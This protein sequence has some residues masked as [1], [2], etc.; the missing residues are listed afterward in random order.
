MPI[1]TKQIRCS[2]VGPYVLDTKEEDPPNFLCS[3]VAC[4]L[5]ALS[6]RELPKLLTFQVSTEHIPN[7]HEGIIVDADPENYVFPCFDVLFNDC[8]YY[9]YIAMQD[10][11]IGECGLRDKDHF[12]FQVKAL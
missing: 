8:Q 6:C 10:F 4:N 9:T 1:Y 2:T 11:L 7:W 12:W 5:L 3:Q